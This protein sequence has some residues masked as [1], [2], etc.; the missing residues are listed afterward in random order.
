MFERF[1]TRSKHLQLHRQGPMRDE[2]E[3]YLRHLVDEGRA[4]DT[5]KHTAGYILHAAILLDLKPGRIVSED[6]LRMLGR[7]WCDGNFRGGAGRRKPS[8]PTIRMFLGRIRHWL[9][10][11]G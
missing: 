5:F 9:T 6:R 1:V 7:E 4:M 11:C 2:R 8:A 10:F 3:R